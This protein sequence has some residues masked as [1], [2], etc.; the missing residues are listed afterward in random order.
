M[1]TLGKN[2]TP[3]KADR[4]KGKMGKKEVVSGRDSERR[5]ENPKEEAHRGNWKSLNEK[6]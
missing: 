4:R 2:S 1:V 3:T 5:R 6:S